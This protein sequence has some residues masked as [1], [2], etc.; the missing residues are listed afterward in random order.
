MVLHGLS[1]SRLGA[2][3][4]V[5]CSMWLIA[6]GCQSIG[7]ELENGNVERVGDSR[8][9]VI[10][11]P[12]SS[13]PQRD[14]RNSQRDSELD[15]AAHD[16]SGLYGMSA[17]EFFEKQSA[18]QKINLDDVNQ[19]LLDATVFHETNRVRQKQGLRPLRHLSDLDEA[20]MLHARSMAR[21]AYLSHQNSDDRL[22]EP[23][24]RARAVGLEPRFVAENIAS[25]FGI[26]Y[27]SGERVYVDDQGRDG[28]TY[29]REPNGPAIPNHT[30]RSFARELVAAWM[31]SPGH[32]RNIL[33]PSAGDSGGGP[34]NMG[35]AC[36][37]GAADDGIPTFYC[38]Q[39]FY[40][41]R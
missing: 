17:E 18:R 12:R 7:G 15:D 14:D 39:M 27:E 6:T 36:V 33:Y 31:N 5:A 35:H 21:E 41:G 28:T 16:A 22:R 1:A 23:I 34:S 24:D 26:R 38:V 40:A 10:S 32:R 25:A 11:R 8:E 4:A 13:N 29:H 30:Y 37:R 19:A 9:Q 3:V 20:A 2:S